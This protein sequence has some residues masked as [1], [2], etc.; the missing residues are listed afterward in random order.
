MSIAKNTA[1]TPLVIN[2]T[3]VNNRNTAGLIPNNNSVNTNNNNSDNT[4]N[5]NSDNTNN[6]NSNNTKCY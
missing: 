2:G 6:N 4:N 1:V 5:N 3:P